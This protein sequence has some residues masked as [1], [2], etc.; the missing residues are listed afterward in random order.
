LLSE[1]R[2]SPTPITMMAIMD[3][4]KVTCRQI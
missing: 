3:E 2:Y 4:G 1:N